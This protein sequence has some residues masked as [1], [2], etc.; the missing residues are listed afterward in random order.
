LDFIRKTKIAA[1][2]AGGITQAIGAYTC[3]VDYVGEQRQV[4][5]LDTPGHEVRCSCSLV[6][7]VFRVWVVVGSAM[8]TRRDGSQTHGIVLCESPLLLLLSSRYSL[9]SFP[10]ATCIA[11]HCIA[12]H[13]IAL[14]PHPPPLLQ[15]FSAMRARGAKV[16]DIV[17][18]IVAADDGV[19]PQTIEA[20]SHAKAAGVPIVVA[21]NKV[22]N[23]CVCDCVREGEEM[24]CVGLRSSLASRAATFATCAPAS[25]RSVPPT[26]PYFCLLPHACLPPPAD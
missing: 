24:G 15:A 22:R 16:T 14:L 9:A 5:F 2:E 1:G 25:P 13:C 19:R 7:H 21:I 10:T 3:D 18:I 26:S 4:T 11:L 20:I 6:C 23:G 8:L 17:I 12:L